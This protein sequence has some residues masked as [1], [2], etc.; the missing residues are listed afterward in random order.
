M[1]TFQA[2]GRSGKTKMFTAV[3]SPGTEI[4][5]GVPVKTFILTPKG[6]DVT[7]K[8]N[9]ADADVDAFPI[10]DGQALQFD[11][12]LAYPI[13]NNAVSIGFVLGSNVPVY[14]AIGY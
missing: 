10:S 12:A 8:F 7:F 6:G 3:V 4:T 2:S 13:A 1:P 14:V 9:S 5:F 11:L